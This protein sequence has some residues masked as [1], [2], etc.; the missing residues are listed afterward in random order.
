MTWSQSF[1]RF[2]DRSSQSILVV[3]YF[4]VAL[5]AGFIWL[6]CLV[7]TTAASVTLSLLH[8]LPR[9]KPTRCSSQKQQEGK[10]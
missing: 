6:L 2:Y 10:H 1:S 7:A 5:L 3:F 9:K 8:K 4:F